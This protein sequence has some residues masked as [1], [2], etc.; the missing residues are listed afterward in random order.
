MPNIVLEPLTRGL[1]QNTGSGLYLFKGAQAVTAAAGADAAIIDV[2]KGPIVNVTS[3]STIFGN[4]TDDDHQMTGSLDVLGPI[5]ASGNISA[6]GN[7]ITIA[8]RVDFSYGNTTGDTVDITSDSITTG[9]A[10]DIRSTSTAWTTGD[11]VRVTISGNA[12]LKIQNIVNEKIH[13]L[14]KIDFQKM[15]LEDSLNSAFPTLDVWL[16]ETFNRINVIAGNQE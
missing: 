10:L 16:A 12:K 7:D 3:G 4:S 2:A 5:T 1:V 6:S 11:A 8:E 15:V 13:Q 14:I 9:S